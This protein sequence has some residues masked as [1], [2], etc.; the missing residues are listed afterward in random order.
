MEAYCILFFLVNILIIIYEYTQNIIWIRASFIAMALFSGLRYEVGVDYQNYVNIFY[1]VSDNLTIKTEPGYQLLIKFA[2][3]LGGTPQLV[4]LIAACITCYFICKFIESECENKSLSTIIYMC[5]GPLYFSSFNTVRESM[6]IAIFLYSL[7][8][9]EEY[10][11]KCILY[12]LFASL[13][14]YSALAF[15]CFII[16]FRTQKSYALYFSMFS[17]FLYVLVKSNVLMVVISTL[18]PR[19]A[20]YVFRPRYNFV[21]DW[22]YTIML[23][24]IVIIFCLR[25][26]ITDSKIEKYYYLLAI[27]G[28]LIIGG[29]STSTIKVIFIR[30]ISYCTPCV[31]VLFP[32][33]GKGIRQKWMYNM[34]V[35]IGCLSYFVYIVNT[36]RDMLPYQMN[37]VLFN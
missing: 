17:M 6:A 34:M 1:Y 8:Y 37:F 36:G 3:L 32:A 25:K 11:W 33:I 18:L 24:L 28:G 20:H 7:R 22:S 35:Y 21:M 31:M 12:M 4:F 2:A 5:L 26:Y 27:M 29:M 23:G 16:F 15:L 9:L 30:L 14:H 13:F 19:Y 10:K